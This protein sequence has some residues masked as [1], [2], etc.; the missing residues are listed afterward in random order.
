MEAKSRERDRTTERTRA[1]ESHKE[2]EWA[3]RRERSSMLSE[4]KKERKKNDNTI[5]TD[6]KAE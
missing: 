2:V 3:K 1:F 4:P 6:S 5:G